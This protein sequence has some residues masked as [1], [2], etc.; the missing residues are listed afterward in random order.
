VGATPLYGVED[1]KAS[2]TPQGDEGKGKPEE[3]ISDQ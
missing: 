1:V 3:G 2:P